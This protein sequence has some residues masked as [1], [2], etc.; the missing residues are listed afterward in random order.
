MQ[1]RY[2]FAPRP[3]DVEHRH[4]F[5]VFDG[6]DRL[7]FHLTIF[8]KEAVARMSESA[9]RTYL[10]AIL[11]FFAYLDEDTWQRQAQKQWNS[12]PHHIRQAVH[13]YLVQHLHCK[14]Q[15]HQLGFQLVRITKGTRSSIGVFLSGL[16]LFYQLMHQ[17]GYYLYNNPLQDGLSAAL[18]HVEE[19]LEQDDHFPPMPETSGVVEPQ[20]THRLS[21]SYFKLE[22]DTWIP[23][24]IDDFT[25]PARVLAGGERLKGWGDRERCVT[26]ILFESGGRI[27]EVTGLTLAD[28]ATRGMGQ[29]VA[30]FS[31]GSYGRRVKFLR[32]SN[33]TAKLLR[34]YFAGE[35]RCIDPN[36][37]T[38]DDYLRESSQKQ[39]DL[40]KIPL[41]LSAQKTQLSAKTYREHFWS[42]AC[43]AA[44]IDAD[45]HQAR[46][47]HV[48]MAVR[49][50][51]TTSQTEAEIGRRLRE[52][53]EYMKWKSGWQTIEA[54]EHYFDAARYAETQDGVHAFLDTALSQGLE[55]CQ[56]LRNLAPE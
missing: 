2:W 49:Q 35:R 5:L 9:V 42:P 47:W 33:D 29:E 24:V 13:D 15:E 23:Q 8:S 22:G 27:S 54:Y 48:T 4:P 40:Q 31:K 7:H 11:P 32:F 50:I 17:R 3:P 52:L 45:I 20:R 28:W 14:V 30:A 26:R 38:L 19:F 12:P 44:G 6:Q 36:G 51:Y 43:R 55:E 1:S 46:H 53:M 16:K 34:R 39:V 37:Y 41:F 21:D 25:F 18:T 10:Y 56:R